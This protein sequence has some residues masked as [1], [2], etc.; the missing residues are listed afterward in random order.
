[1]KRMITS[2]IESNYISISDINIVSVVLTDDIEDY[3]PRDR[4]IYSASKTKI[5][6]STL[7]RDQLL[8]LPER[9]LQNIHDV[10]ILRKLNRDE[11]TL[12][13]QRE[14]AIANQENFESELKEVKAG[15]AKLKACHK[16]YI[17]DTEKNNTFIDTVYKMG[18]E[19]TDKDALNIIHNLH[20]KDYS[21]STYSYIDKNWNSLLM[22]FEYNNPYTFGPA[23]DEGE[24][25]Q[26]DNLDIYIKIDVDKETR[27]GYAAMSFHA[28][29]GQMHHPYA[30]FPVDRE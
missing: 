12:Q 5:D 17:W 10:R 19:V 25:V 3:N 21:Y 18:G 6:Y 30:D 15:L 22:I 9:T 2:S 14:V 16:V 1:M 11:L 23:E 24:P 26:V 20:V 8:G 29:E 28:P 7:T 13:Q 27:R 4:S